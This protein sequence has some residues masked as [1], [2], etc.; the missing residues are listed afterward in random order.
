[1]LVI[2]DASELLTDAELYSLEDSV[3]DCIEK[4]S[5]AG[6]SARDAAVEKVIKMIAISEKVQADGTLARQLRRKCV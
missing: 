3:V 2:T 6:A 5:E 1:M 4:M